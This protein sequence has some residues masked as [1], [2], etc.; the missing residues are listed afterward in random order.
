MESVVMYLPTL[1]HPGIPQLIRTRSGRYSPVLENMSV[2]SMDA[3]S[4]SEE[5]MK[6]ASVSGA[7]ARAKVRNKQPLVFR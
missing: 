5:S 3:K 2:R 7:K 4:T 6:R 1:H